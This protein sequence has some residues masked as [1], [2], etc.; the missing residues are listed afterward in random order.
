MKKNWLPL[1][2]LLAL[3]ACSGERYGQIPFLE[4]RDINAS[5][6]LS[7]IYSTITLPDRPL[8]LTDIINYAAD[9]NLDIKVKQLEWEIQK[10]IATGERLRML[11]ELSFNGEFSRRN[12]TLASTGELIGP[13]RVLLPAAT[14]VDSTSRR[15]DATL[16]LNLLDFGLAYFRSRQDDDQ[17]TVVYFQYARLRQNLVLDI[18]KAYWKAIAARKALANSKDVLALSKE[19]KSALDRNLDKRLLSEIV[20]L[21]AEDQILNLQLQLYTY[22]EIYM[23][24]KAELAALM[25]IPASICFELADVNIDELPDLIDISDME[26]LAIRSR[27]E[28]FGADFDELASIE[29]VRVEIL[30]M[31]PGIQLFRG[32]HSD[33]DKFLVHHH[34]IL[35]GA[36]AAWNL[37]SIPSHVAN[38]QAAEFRVDAS[39]ETRLALSIGVL[40]QVHLAYWKYQEALAQFKIRRDI[41][42]VRT[43]LQ[44]AAR[45]E[46]AQGEFQMLDVLNYDANAV[47][48]EISLMQTYGD[49]EI[50]LEQLNNTLGQPLLFNNIYIDETNCQETSQD[51]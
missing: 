22:E 19:M 23:G 48:A 26:D 50:S 42:E 25:G 1:A 43:K 38:T 51:E 30:Q 21:Q 7:Q 28:L 4:Q 15:W 35:T 46:Y 27:P 17:A 32:Y 37:L 10:E 20:A 40:S 11:P 13:P 14:T 8:T 44:K 41:Y 18:F 9:N 33:Y 16:A 45:A 39:H 3:T 12:N 29:A 31:F 5:V 6:D 24:A 2:T 47:L 36:R 34:W 49:V